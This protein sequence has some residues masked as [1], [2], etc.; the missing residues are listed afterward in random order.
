MC[1]GGCEFVSVSS[2]R[3]GVFS[4]QLLHAPLHPPTGLTLVSIQC[5]A[6]WSDGPTCVHEQL[7]SSLRVHCPSIVVTIMSFFLQ[8]DDSHQGQEGE[9]SE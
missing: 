5:D 7:N 4:L 1:V 9:K 2:S 8:P 3:P 6:C